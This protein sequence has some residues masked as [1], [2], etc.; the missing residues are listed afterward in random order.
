VLLRRFAMTSR[1]TQP[2]F[3]S[4]FVLPGLDTSQPA[5]DYRVDLDEEAIDGLSR[6]AW[7]RVA[8]SYTCRRSHCIV[9]LT[10]WFRS[11]QRISMPT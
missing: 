9:P 6:L 11:S 3:S 5:G 2:V 7:R 1:T 4:P 8:A 10:R